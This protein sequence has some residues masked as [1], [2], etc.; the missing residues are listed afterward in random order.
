MP[1]IKMPSRRPFTE[2][3]KNFGRLKILLAGHSG[4][5]LACF[6]FPAV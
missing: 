1:S 4:M 2:T 3:G 5:H 6:Q